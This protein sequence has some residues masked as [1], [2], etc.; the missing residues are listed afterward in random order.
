MPYFFPPPPSEMKP[1]PVPLVLA[2]S[3]ADPTTSPVSSPS[4]SSDFPASSAP[5]FA[6]AP[7]GSDALGTVH[8]VTEQLGVGGL[9]GLAT[10]YSIRRLG[11]IIAFAVGTEVLLLQYLAYR[12]WLVMDWQRV[13]QDLKPKGDGRGFWSAGMDIVLYKLP[14]ASAFSAGMAA[15]LRLSK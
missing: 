4:T 15:G 7:P 1:R 6:P 12:R 3:P 2:A 13:A 11:R 5:A 9:L 14:F 10:G 8:S